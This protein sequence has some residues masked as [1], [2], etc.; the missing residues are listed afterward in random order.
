MARR[1]SLRSQ[2]SYGKSGWSDDQPTGTQGV[3]L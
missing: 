3:A 1:K 2:T